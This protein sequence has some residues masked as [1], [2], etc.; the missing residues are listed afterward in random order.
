MDV[1]HGDFDTLT[2]ALGEA[3]TRRRLFGLL[4][5]LPVLGG[6]FALLGFG[7]DA[8]AK[9][10]RRRR[11][12]GH[13][14]GKGHGR[15]RKGKRKCK[16]HSRARTC[17]GKCGPVKNNCKKTVTC[18]CGC[19]VCATNCAFT[20]IQAAIDDPATQ[21]G[22]TITI[23]AGRYIESVNVTRNLT[24]QGAGDGDDEAVDTILDGNLAN[25]VVQIGS[26]KDVTL[27][28]LRITRG[29]VLNGGGGGIFNQGA[30][31]MERCTVF[32]NETRNADGGGGI[33]QNNPATGLTATDCTIA[34]N[35]SFTN[36]GWGG[37]IRSDN[38]PNLTLTNCVIRDNV[39]GTNPGQGAGGALYL[40]PAAAS[41]TYTLTGCQVGPGN[42]A[43]IGGAVYGNP[44]TTLI[45]DATTVSD[46]H[47]TVSTGGGL[48]LQQGS[49]VTLRNGSV[50]SGNT[51]VQ[52]G[53]GIWNLGVL[54]IDDSVVGPDNAATGSGGGIYNMRIPISG[55][56]F[57]AITLSG[58][59]EVTENH[60]GTTGGGI[61]N[62][63]TIACGG[64]SVTL[65]TAGDPE[66]ASNCVNDVDGVGC[67][68]CP[69]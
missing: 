54:E 56:P 14:H 52:N 69:A 49:D 29:L 34:Q 18:P 37:G 15:H 21:D 30:L 45:L 2:R 40:Q 50:V 46:N 26:G 38:S 58:G 20:T 39:G 4:A 5:T 9:G 8:E 27:R 64:G 24:L 41:T 44:L 63:G 31:T 23:C 17:A 36:Q 10:R 61:F 53:G 47:A 59:A 13:K 57:G 6:L 16:A 32:D 62:K 1:R 55:G 51:A 12:K 19:D 48:Q 33:Y 35:R 43:A 22:D 25:R 60:A 28:D 3:G 42:Q 67:D 7:E 65:N 68:T 11:K 66:V